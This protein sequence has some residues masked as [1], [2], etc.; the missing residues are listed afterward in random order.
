MLTNKYIVNNYGV[1]LN[2]DNIFS[3][4]KNKYSSFSISVEIGICKNGLW[5][6]GLTSSVNTMGQA[7]PCKTGVAQTKKE[8]IL[9]A[10]ILIDQL[11][12]YY[13]KEG[14][15]K[16][17]KKAKESLFYFKIKHSK[18]DDIITNKV[19]EKEIRYVQGTLF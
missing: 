17:I 3:I 8:A 13:S 4:E 10:I 11:L 12:E 7:T 15:Q 9:K 14:Y 6:I 1:V 16:Q 2:A 5:G 19:P 18:T